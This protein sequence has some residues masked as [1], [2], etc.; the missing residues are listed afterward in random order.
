[1]GSI[2]GRLL[3]AAAGGHPGCGGRRRPHSNPD[4]SAL[5]ERI[6][7]VSYQMLR[8]ELEKQKRTQHQQIANSNYTCTT[9]HG[10][11]PVLETRSPQTN[12]VHVRPL[13]T[14]LPPP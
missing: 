11:E 9:G 4:P 6:K 5:D 7:F 3:A 14:Y 10:Q 2:R 13:W 8:K 1:M 12:S